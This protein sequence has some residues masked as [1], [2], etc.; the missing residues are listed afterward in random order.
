MC[1][2]LTNSFDLISLVIIFIATFIMAINAPKN[3][4]DG[5]FC[6]DVIDFEKPRKRERNTKIGLI[7]LCIGFFIQLLSLIIKTYKDSHS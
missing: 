1:I 4:P 3:K 6:S 2:S 7:I 5:A